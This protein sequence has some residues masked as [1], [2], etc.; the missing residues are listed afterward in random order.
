MARTQSAFLLRKDV[1]DR[2]ALQKSIDALKFKV[3][4]DD[5]YVPF[6]SS[7][8]L[9][10]TYDGEDAGFT[11]KFHNL[12]P[13]TPAL[14]GQLGERDTVIDFK[15][16]GDVREYVSAMAVC[17]ALAKDFGAIVHDPD[18]DKVYSADQLVKKVRT[19]E[20]EAF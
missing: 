14:Q 1:P 7:G 2:Q 10:C 9:P 4:L 16:S 5:G 19:A 15:W 3:T 8:Y 11:I 6:E 12:L 20:E 13:H 18:G 17:A